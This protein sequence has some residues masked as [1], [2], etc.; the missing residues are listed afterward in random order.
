MFFCL[1]APY[2]V[3]DWCVT[4][5]VLLWLALVMWSIFAVL[6]LSTAGSVNL[7]MIAVLG[8]IAV[9]RFMLPAIPGIGMLLGLP[10]WRF[11]PPAG[12]QAVLEDTTLLPLLLQA[13]LLATCLAA[14]ARKYRRNDIRAFSPELG[15]L[16]VLELTLLGA[17]GIRDQ[18]TFPRFA[19]MGA[20]ALGDQ[21]TASILV[22]TLFAF[23]PISA[24][25]QAA[26]TASPRNTRRASELRLAGACLVAV[27]VVAGV[28]WLLLSD[29]PALRLRTDARTWKLTTLFV[30]LAL[31][32]G[33]AIMQ[34]FY[35]WRERVVWLLGAWLFAT[36]VLPPA[37][38][39]TLLAVMDVPA[40][41]AYQWIP[42]LSPAGA[43]LM[44]WDRSAGELWPG[45]MTQVTM[46]LA[47]WA[48][49]LWLRPARD[50]DLEHEEV[51][52]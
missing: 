32:P 51:M 7:L 17:F 29:A 2:P 38:H 43:L 8:G 25:A 21:M 27:V 6:A 49:T 19:T 28:H 41:S 47:V 9:G 10:Y 12:L 22:T 23:I 50:V 24:A 20:G 15:L 13:A 36:W 16:L 52:T 1:W 18:S 46:C 44:V 31:L 39:M 35:R 37:V 34:L 3:W 4:M 48:S 45:I 5:A 11:G 33:G 42:G 14:T 26:A 40:H 30:A